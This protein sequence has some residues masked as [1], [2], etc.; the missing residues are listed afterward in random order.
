MPQKPPVMFI[1]A[2]KDR[3][4][5]LFRQIA[6]QLKKH[7]SSGILSEGQRL[8][9]VRKLASSLQVSEDTVQQAYA[10]LLDEGCVIAKPRSGYFV[11]RALPPAGASPHPAVRMDFPAGMP[12]RNALRLEEARKFGDAVAGGDPAAAL[13]SGAPALDEADEKAWVAGSVRFARSPWLQRQGHFTG[14]LPALRRAI[15]GR[16]REFRGIAC[17]PDSVVVTGGMR[18][19]LAL[20]M[21]L[22]FQP[23]DPVLLESPTSPAV[24]SLAYFAGLR[25]C[26]GEVDGDGL[27]FDPS[28]PEQGA[29]RGAVV[30]PASEAPLGVALQRKRKKALLIWAKRTGAV[31]VE[32]DSGSSLCQNDTPEMALR[33]APFGEETVAYCGDFSLLVPPAG[34]VGFVL[35]PKGL[36]EAF[37]GAARLWGA[38]PDE[39]GQRALEAFVSSEAFDARVRKATALCRERLAWLREEAEGP[40]LSR[41]GRLLPAVNGVRAAFLLEGG[42][43]PRD[44]K[45]L[46]A[47]GKTPAVAALSRFAP[48]GGNGFVINF[49]AGTGEGLRETLRRLAAALAKLQG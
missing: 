16:L 18:Q 28:D 38:V 32:N 37:A 19:S 25:P 4:K 5:P 30:S 26:W 23:G 22:L 9:G 33:A 46:E 49:A 34:G 42:G 47:A 35:A 8:P 39:A 12:S 45:V 10:Q 21:Q 41:F 40:A 17:E 36:E 29:C 14:G 2:R 48:G 11:A 13:A 3:E 43:A 7:I 31:L 27:R 44:S 6:D 24:A 15:A 1:Q 20:A